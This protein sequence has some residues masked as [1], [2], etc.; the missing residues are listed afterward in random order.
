MNTSPTHFLYY[1]ALE[2][3][4]LET[5]LEELFKK[6]DS[7]LY[8][9]PVYEN[10]EQGEQCLWCEDPQAQLK[11]EKKKAAELATKQKE[12][13]QLL[14]EKK[15][16]KEKEEAKKRKLKELEL[17]HKMA[18]ATNI[19]VLKEEFCKTGK[20][21]RFTCRFFIVVFCINCIVGGFFVGRATCE[22]PLNGFL[23]GVGLGILSILL[24]RFIVFIWE[25]E[26]E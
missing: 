3:K 18:L 23:L 22:D 12:Q 5:S 26:N 17:T 10:E 1:D 21:V 19:A 15:K 8:I 7:E 2:E 13:E 6:N 24:V 9:I 14:L 25:P 4:W 20:L 16:E 11:Y